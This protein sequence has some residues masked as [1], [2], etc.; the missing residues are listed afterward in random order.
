MMNEPA[1]TPSNEMT[2]EEK[3]NWFRLIGKMGGNA[4]KRKYGREY[5]SRI[6]EKGG[7][8]MLHKIGA[9]G[10]SKLGKMSKKSERPQL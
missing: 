3:S 4:T 5:Y 7:I 10:F 2:P 6:G 8:A 9:E 1:F